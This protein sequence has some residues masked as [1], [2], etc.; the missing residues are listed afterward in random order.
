MRLRVTDHALV[1][2]LSRAGGL[3]VD[4]LRPQLA[5]SLERAARAADSLGASEYRIQADG[6]EYRVINGAVVTVI[7]PADRTERPQS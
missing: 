2:F 6:L 3:D 7:D 1:R 5:R 4:A